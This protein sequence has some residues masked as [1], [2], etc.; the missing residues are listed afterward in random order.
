MTSRPRRRAIA[1][2]AGVLLAAG[3]L[4]ACS[5]D[6]PPTPAISGE[7]PADVTLPTLP[8]TTTSAPAPTTGVPTPTTIADAGTPTTEAG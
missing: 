7:N 6:G 4:G 5:D 2:A 1:L 8:P 3:A